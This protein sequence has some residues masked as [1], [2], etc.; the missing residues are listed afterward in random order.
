MTDD[1]SIDPATTTTPDWILQ[2]QKA[3]L[4]KASPCP[5]CGRCP[6]CGKGGYASGPQWPIYPDRW[7]T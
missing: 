5:S 6:T 7:T 1:K 4:H 2:L 3:A